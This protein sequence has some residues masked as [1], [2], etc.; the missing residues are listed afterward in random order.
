MVALMFTYAIFIP[1]PWRRAARL[2]VPMA[3]APMT[4]PWILGAF[5][6]ELYQVAV[7]AASL[8]YMSEDGLF[9]V[10]AHSRRFMER[11]RSTRC[12]SRPTAPGS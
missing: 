12:G 9:L 3:L 6:P 2:I 1:N 11:T 5:H 7:K 4:V 8:E 10:L